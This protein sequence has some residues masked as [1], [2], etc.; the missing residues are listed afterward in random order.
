MLV[1]GELLGEGE[2]CAYPRGGAAG[3][4]GAWQ[5]DLN[6]KSHSGLVPARSRLIGCPRASVGGFAEDF[7]GAAFT[8]E[9]TGEQPH[10]LV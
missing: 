2:G 9:T 1:T 6:R 8:V 3:A 5:S 10:N 7:V 4:P